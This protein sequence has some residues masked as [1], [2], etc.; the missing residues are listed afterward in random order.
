[1]P[2]ASLR[3]SGQ[4][5]AVYQVVLTRSAKRDLAKLDAT[6]RRRVGEKLRYLATTPRGMDTTKVVSEDTFR[7]RVGDYR[8][9]F[10]IDDETH[11]VTV[12]RIEH[13]S[14]VYR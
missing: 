4:P 7:T 12:D 6:L 14:D 2:T 11:T 5:K 13:R 8:I 10:T 1:M 3:G 9:V